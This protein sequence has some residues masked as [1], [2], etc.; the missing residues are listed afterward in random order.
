[1]REGDAVV[2][3]EG[4]VVAVAEVAHVDGAVLTEDG[5]RDGGVFEALA[6]RKGRG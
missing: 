1:M 2:G 5:A 6:G 3:L 4:R